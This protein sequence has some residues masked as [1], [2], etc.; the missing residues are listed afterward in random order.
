MGW[1]QQH[2]QAA[3]SSSHP[4]NVTWTREQRLQWGFK[5]LGPRR[6]KKESLDSL[7]NGE[8]LKAFEKETARIKSVLQN[9]RYAAALGR[10]GRGQEA[11]S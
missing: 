4:R 7:G 5:T 6:G 2:S 8:S 1:Q 11:G 9:T 10:K 3:Q